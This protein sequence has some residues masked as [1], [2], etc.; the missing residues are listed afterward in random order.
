MSPLQGVFNPLYS[1]VVV[2]LGNHDNTVQITVA[3][4]A[5]P[6][7]R[8]FWIEKVRGSACE[9]QIQGRLCVL[10]YSR[11]GNKKHVGASFIAS[12]STNFQKLL[13]KCPPFT[14]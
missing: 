8:R 6:V 5:K 7:T 3:G 10:G 13:F 14:T 1:Y 9:T 2:V 11:R 12:A 4:D